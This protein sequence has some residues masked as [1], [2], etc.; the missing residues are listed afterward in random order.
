M[1]LIV[2][3]NVG[4]ANHKNANRTNSFQSILGGENAFYKRS[5]YQTTTSK[6]FTQNSLLPVSYRWNTEY[7]IIRI[8]KQL[9]SIII[10]PIGIYKLIHFLV[11][12]LAIVPASTPSLIGYRKNHAIQSRSAILKKLDGDFKYKRLTIEVDGYQID[13]TILGKPSTLDNGRWILASNGNAEFYE[14]KLHSY[15]FKEILSRLNANAIVFNYPGVGASTGLPNR[16]AMAKAYRAILAFAED[17]QNG[18]DAK[19]IIGY[20]HSIGGG[21]QGDALNMHNLKKDVKYVFIKSRTFSDLSTEV[22]CIIAKIAGFLVKVIGWNISSI[23]SSIQLRAPEIILQ[24]AAF[25]V[26]G[27]IAQTSGFFNLERYVLG[28]L[29]LKESS[30]IIDDGVIRA[31]ASLAKALL[32]NPKCFKNKVFLGIRE[33]HNDELGNNSLSCLIQKINELLS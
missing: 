22:S 24:T 31:E 17:K 21:V 32:D 27:I 1:S 7:K 2:S 15:E 6:E 13:T 10:F 9:L 20:G 26:P 16:Q 12:K 4:I 11:G 18:L 23:K 28:S 19:E 33:K 5:D 25:R 14:D 29:E 30:R 8:T 3:S